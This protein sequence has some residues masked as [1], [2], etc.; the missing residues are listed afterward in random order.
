MK[1]T[2]GGRGRL[3]GWTVLRGLAIGA[4]T[5]V[6]LAVLAQAVLTALT[7]I[8]PP[9]RP[10]NAQTPPIEVKGERAY[11]GPNW[12]TRERG[13]WELHLEG[14]PWDM[15]YAHA[16]LG[17]RLLM[18]TE[19]YMFAEMNRYVPS[20]LAMW[21]IR[22]GVRWQYRHLTESIPRDVL[23]E[24]AGQAEGYHDTHSDF[25][26]GFHRMIF[27]H[28]LHDITQGLEHSPML[29]CTAFAVS[30]TATT[31]GHLLVGRNF[32]FE[33]PEPF[34]RDKAVLFFKPAHGIPF[35]SV[36]W[37]GESG[38]VTG[39]NLE[40]LY[41]SINAA[42]T[43]DKSNGTGIPVEILLREILETSRTLEEAIKK[44]REAKVIVPDLYL[45][46]DGKTGESA[47]VE[48]SPTRTEV[49]R[50]RDVLLLT[51]HALTPAFAADAENDRLRR[52]LTSGARYRRLSEVVR[53]HKGG[54]DP[55]KVAE[56]LRDKMG[57]KG[58]T[59]GLGNRN[60]IDA[61]IATH[62]VVVDATGL[63]IWV[64]TGP[65]ILGRYVG[66]DLRK[67][68][69]GEPRESP[70][71]IPADPMEGSDEVR[72]WRLATD[73]LR[74]AEALRTRAPQRA[75]ES[76]ERAVGYEEMM[77]E[78]HRLIGDLVRGTDRE[79]ARREYQRFLELSPPYLHDI[80]EVKGILTAL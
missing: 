22:L 5:L 52:Y 41:V 68:L 69:A 67:E 59:L 42:R 18:A 2:L 4:V 73:E 21:A 20:K 63:T 26:P 39:L 64:S 34:D 79:R 6:V 71:D 25:L 80:E 74:T 38:V 46:A 76:A 48:R 37:T 58:A 62:S 19:D 40:G 53:Q 13:L 61:L 29:G 9:P 45:I 1:L 54:F 78:P 10:A 12:M 24:I 56:V 72:R 75:L 66:Y 31:S 15:G 23:L 16:R 8:D 27:Y 30:G 14:E 33:G 60:A 57:E 17:T 49:R 35:V 50:A 65:H 44:V 11:V 28:A 70:P 36:A 3:K 51:N 43:D 77:P 47:V 7:R 55:K 32:D